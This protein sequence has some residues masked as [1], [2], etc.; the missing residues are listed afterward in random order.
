MLGEGQTQNLPRGWNLLRSIAWKSI[1]HPTDPWKPGVGTLGSLLYPKRTARP[2]RSS[3]PA[4]SS[5]SN[6]H[7]WTGPKPRSLF[8]E[9]KGPRSTV[10]G[11]RDKLAQ[12]WFRP[13][14]A[15]MLCSRLELPLYIS[16]EKMW[17][18]MCFLFQ[19]TELR[20]VCRLSRIH[21][22]LKCFYIFIY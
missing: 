14:P 15:G 22:S 8:S 10:P 4:V 21:F 16:V 1:Q 3:R 7:G 2:S 19:P 5:L 20:E 9:K 13:C 17:P 12:A 6:V 11:T 18:Q